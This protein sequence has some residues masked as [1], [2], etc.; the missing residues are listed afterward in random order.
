MKHVSLLIRACLLKNHIKGLAAVLIV[1]FATGSIVSGKTSLTLKLAY[2]IPN[3]KFIQGFPQFSR[4]GQK[5]LIFNHSGFDA[6]SGKYKKDI[7][8][9]YQTLTGKLLYSLVFPSMNS[10]ILPVLSQDGNLLAI[11]GKDACTYKASNNSPYLGVTDDSLGYISILKL[12]SGKIKRALKSKG[13]CNHGF[14]MFNPTGKILAVANR[15][16]GYIQLWDTNKGIL[17]Q[18]IKSRVNRLHTLNFS[19]DGKL[20]VFC[21][22]GAFIWNIHAASIIRKLPSKT[23][24]DAD[25]PLFSLNNRFLIVT[26]RQIPVMLWEISK[27][28]LIRE[29]QRNN[30]R[31]PVHT[32]MSADG[33]MLAIN[34]YGGGMT[35]YKINSGQIILK[36]NF[37]LAG[38]S[39]L[40]LPGGIFTPINHLILIWNDQNALQ[41]WKVQ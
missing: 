41:L 25:Q 29:F 37:K 40:V 33:S 3:S 7:Y 9:V 21:E 35:I 12:P 24:C 6:E 2:K 38:S 20:L 32:S 23:S 4:D 18:T 30:D 14:M 26:I 31:G 8:S 36:H 11:P 15:M 13:L 10:N 39:Y 27:R 19:H 5:F 34:D 22:Y 17:L 28:R 16:W 1:C